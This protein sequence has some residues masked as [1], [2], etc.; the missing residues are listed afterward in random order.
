[1]PVARTLMRISPAPGSF[2][3]RSS[4]VRGALTSLKRAALKVLGKGG[5]M[6][7]T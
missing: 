7:E 6:I 2:K 4:K 5:D 1:M 3:S